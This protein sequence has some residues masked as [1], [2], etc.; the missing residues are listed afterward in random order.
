MKDI[1]ITRGAQLLTRYIAIVLACMAAWVAGGDARIDD[2]TTSAINQLAEPI[3][4]AFASF[5]ALVADL[6]IHRV[7]LG[8]WFDFGAADRKGGA[9]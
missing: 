7:K 2:T 3:G 8:A 4:L 9:S 6:A 5:V 1:I